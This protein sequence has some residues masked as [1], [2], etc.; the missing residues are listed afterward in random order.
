MRLAVHSAVVGTLTVVVGCAAEPIVEVDN[1]PP[2]AERK[3]G[4]RDVPADEAIAIELTVP[5][6]PVTSD[7]VEATFTI[8]VFTHV[9]LDGNG[10]GDVTDAMIDAQIKVLNDAYAGATGGANM[11]MIFENA[12]VTRTTNAQWF[13]VSP[14]T[15]AERDMKSTLRQGG[16]E[17]LNMYLAD[18]GGGL[19]GWAT[20]PS[21]YADDPEVDGVVVLNT[22]LPGGGAAPFDEGDTA[23]H[24]VGHW[25]GLFHTFQNSC[26]A[27]GDLVK[28]TPRVADP[29]FGCPQAIDSCPSAAGDI[30]RPDLIT[31]FMDYVDDACM[32]AFTKGQSSRANRYYSR[33]RAGT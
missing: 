5:G 1:P 32:T 28:D 31:N 9:I 33:F 20:F 21:D 11:K 8:P 19:L 10:A 15:A 12:G 23:T 7:F 13:H 25:V 30:P 14:G 17:T 3:C 4:S 22:S 26:S 18:L 29:N 2:A 24:E 27:P 16:P 6:D